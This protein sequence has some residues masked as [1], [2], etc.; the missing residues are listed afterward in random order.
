MATNPTIVGEKIKY[1]IGDSV[2]FMP[3]IVGLHRV[4][5]YD[6]GLF[7]P[8]CRY[9]PPKADIRR[10]SWKLRNS[11]MYGIVRAAA[12]KCNTGPLFA[13][14]EGVIEKNNKSLEGGK[15]SKYRCFFEVLWKAKKIEALIS[16]ELAKISGVITK[17]ASTVRT[18]ALKELSYK[19]DFFRDGHAFD[20]AF[21]FLRD[22]SIENEKQMKSIFGFTGVNVGAWAGLNSFGKFWQEYVRVISE[23]AKYE[24][25][26]AQHELLMINSFTTIISQ[27]HG[28]YDGLISKLS[29]KFDETL[30]TAY[31][32]EKQVPNDSKMEQKSRNAKEI[33]DEYLWNVIFERLEI[34]DSIVDT[35]FSI[36]CGSR[37]EHIPLTRKFMDNAVVYCLEPIFKAVKNPPI[38]NTTVKHGEKVDEQKI[39]RDNERAD[40]HLFFTSHSAQFKTLLSLMK[41]DSGIKGKV[42]PFSPKDLHS[43][44]M[45]VSSCLMVAAEKNTHKLVGP[46]PKDDS[47]SELFSS[48]ET[49]MTNLFKTVPDISL[50]TLIDKKSKNNADIM[51]I[52]RSPGIR[53]DIFVKMHALCSTGNASYDNYKKIVYTNLFSDSVSY[54][55]YHFK[56]FDDSVLVQNSYFRRINHP[57]S[58]SLTF[59]AD[60]TKQGEPQVTYNNTVRRISRLPAE[61]VPPTP[62]ASGTA[63]PEIPPAVTDIL[64]LDK[65]FSPTNSK[66]IPQGAP[67]PP[68]KSPKNK[69]QY[70]KSK[71]H[72]GKGGSNGPQKTIKKNTNGPKRGGSGNKPAKAPGK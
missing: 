26:V 47:K 11:K 65:D 5:G 58:L 31:F 53:S 67:S 71:N 39:K 34:L 62:T 6:M 8:L 19:L 22:N 55:M 1:D 50:E 7:E 29:D 46:K 28:M 70:P 33:I 59:K 54:A 44:R 43:L 17:N 20:V 64:V 49:F 38:K 16:G 3:L 10:Q 32:K 30:V 61:V 40:I 57:F 56:S 45:S 48:L 69:K 60:S 13:F 9:Q 24:A 27:Y 4:G 68:K 35:F 37:R 41:D 23:V 51:R 66:N 52:H 2:A 42:T 21:N 15:E 72:R 36:C 12:K 25:K 63:L 18:A 14:K